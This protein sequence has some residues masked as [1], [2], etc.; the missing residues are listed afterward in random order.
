MEQ[1]KVITAATN[2]YELISEYPDSQEVLIEYGIPC[3]SCHFSSYD[4]IAD[5]IAEFGI[6]DEDVKDMLEQLN[7]IVKKTEPKK[8][9]E[10]ELEDGSEA[11]SL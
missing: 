8:K 6:E 9:E 2:V 7:E 4:T 11:A 5:S 3:A 1:Q 10:N